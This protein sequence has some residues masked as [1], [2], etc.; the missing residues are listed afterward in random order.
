MVFSHRPLTGCLHWSL[1]PHAESSGHAF[2][3]LTGLVDRL[4]LCCRIS[5]FIRRAG[6]KISQLQNRKV[7]ESSGLAASRLDEKLFWTHNDSGDR[8]AALLF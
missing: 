7:N 2:V 6:Y 1:R 3:L 8:P 4:R 5:W